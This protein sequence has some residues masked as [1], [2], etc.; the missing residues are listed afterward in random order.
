MNIASLSVDLHQSCSFRHLNKC[1]Q[2]VPKEAEVQV[3]R[4]PGNPTVGGASQFASYRAIVDAVADRLNA[5]KQIQHAVSQ[6]QN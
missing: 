1:L 5:L 3:S 2:L 4:M 6:P